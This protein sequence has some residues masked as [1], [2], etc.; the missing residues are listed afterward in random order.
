MEDTERAAGQLGEP[1]DADRQNMDAAVQPGLFDAAGQTLSLHFRATPDTVEGILA[2]AQEWAAQH[3]LARDDSLSLRLVLDELLANICMHAG[4]DANGLVDMRLE[5][6]GGTG[7][8][9]NAA[10]TPQGHVRIVL[11]DT[12]KPFNPLQYE[13]Q[14]M[15]DIPSAQVGGRG[16]TLVRL[17]TVNHAYRWTGASNHF[18]LDLPLAGTSET[19]GGAQHHA[20]TEPGLSVLQRLRA[21]WS[22]NLALR[23]TVIFSLCALA[24][25]WGAM[26]LYYFQVEKVRVANATA[27]A[28]QALHT[29]SVISSTF[30]DR[31]GN[32]VQA[33]AVQARQVSRSHGAGVDPD[34]LV[35]D[36]E[37]ASQLRS[38]AAEIPVRGLVMGYG[39]KT[40]LYDVRGGGIQKELLGEDLTPLVGRNGQPPQW[41]SVFIRFGEDNPHAAMLYGVP[42][43]PADDADKT[44]IGTIITM[45]WIA[46]TLKGLS[47]FQNSVPVFF[48][49]DGRYIIYP[50]GRQMHQGPQ[51]LADEARQYQAPRLRLLEKK[52]LAGEQGE[53][54]LASVVNGNAT[55]WPLPWSGPT[56]L[57]YYPMKTPG[58][59]LALLVSS[60]ELGDA[61]QDVPVAFIWMAVLGPLCIGGLTWIVASRTLRPL[62]YLASSLER[63]SQGDLDAP[64]PRARFADEIGR[65][66]E[67]F[68]RVRV[69]LRASFRNLV[70]SA[71]EQQRIR[72]ELELARNIQQSM[73]PRKFPQLPWGRV[74]AVTE[75]CSEVCGDLN[76]CFIQHP[77]DPQKL[78]CIVGD[79]CGKGIPAALIMS[80]AMSLARAFL[81]AG[82]SPA[83][84]LESINNAL[85]RQD[86]S[87]MFVTM[88]VGILDQNGEFVWASAGHPPPVLGPESQTGIVETPA[89]SLPWP[90]ELVLGVRKNLRYT[91][92][93]LQVQPGQSLLLY[94][95]GADEAQGPA[96]K[97]GE[98]AG[99]EL[100]GEARL[101]ESFAGAC[102]ECAE[103][104]PAAVVERLWSDIRSHMQGCAPL[105]DI[106]LMVITR[107]KPQGKQGLSAD[108]SP[109]VN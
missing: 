7:G 15:T 104:E 55:P 10:C 11:Q 80:R 70:N 63:F 53:V 86:N 49:K 30:V 40:W 45:P 101:V 64:V 73:L 100:F 34:A 57:A 97:K 82:L 90:G 96:A 29:Q 18:C 1:P 32:A 84:T 36:L 93:R 21:L 48:N 91:L 59:Y 62:H 98:S 88:L 108:A 43:N 46:G 71:A 72:N 20:A 74:H 25:I 66:L 2:I 44:W 52:I 6:A 99:G 41:E 67:I 31:V 14:P 13:P 42:L 12:G 105:D 56:S 87:S 33:L 95:D 50:V 8:R 4:A 27:R 58:W 94:T 51:S 89:R 107:V 103:A 102:R 9:N 61:P 37:K 19:A 24:L 79:V 16:L 23:L 54:Q 39:G 85:L 81:L 69:T 3:G 68:E 83:H 26:A 106:S 75:M 77:A 60:E 76:D 5:I 22:G 92:H 17:L 78:C 47:G 35:R 109:G 65:M 38:L 28:M